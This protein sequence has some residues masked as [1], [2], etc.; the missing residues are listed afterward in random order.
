M[1]FKVLRQ[2]PVTSGLL[3]SLSNLSPCHQTSV[4]KSIENKGNSTHMTT[5]R[6]EHLPLDVVKNQKPRSRR[7]PHI[8]E[9]TETHHR[10]TMA[11]HS[12]TW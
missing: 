9:S 11:S 3:A 5:Y 4:F 7:N 1:A 2:K 6:A 8:S 12:R 10:E